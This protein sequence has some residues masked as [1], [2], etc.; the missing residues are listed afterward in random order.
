MMKTTISS[1]HT[2]LYIPAIQKLALHLPHVRI[3]GTNH[4]DEMRRTAF[5]RCES[6]QDF[7]CRRD[8]AER[9]VASFAN[10]TQSDGGNRSVSILGIALEH[11]SALPKEHINSS[12]I[13]SHR[14]A[15]FHYFLSD[16]SKQDTATNTSHR[17]RLISLL[18]NKKY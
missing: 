2:S 13:S 5:K 15:L 4:C 8:Y 10:K 16:N 7:L 9:V 11:L 18:K 6:F 12:T 14:H 3:L 1:F 17:K